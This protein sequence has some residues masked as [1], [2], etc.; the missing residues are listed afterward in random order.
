MLK[1][2]SSPLKPYTYVSGKNAICIV[3]HYNKCL[4]FYICKSMCAL[5]GYSP[6]QSG[7]LKGASLLGILGCS[8]NANNCSITGL[9]IIL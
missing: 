5:C 9:I 2:C 7:I 1:T 6:R 4:Y 3:L 8:R